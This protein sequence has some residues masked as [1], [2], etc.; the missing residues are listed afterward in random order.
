[1]T[2]MFSHADISYYN[3]LFL[4][5]YSIEFS[6]HGYHLFRFLILL[7]N[8]Q[9]KNLWTFLFFFNQ[10]S[11]EFIGPSGTNNSEYL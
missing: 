8:L 5:I 10:N 3:F 2:S 6:I 4:L 1:M 11:S 9:I 7:M